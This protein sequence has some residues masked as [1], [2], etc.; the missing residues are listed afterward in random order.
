MQRQREGIAIAKQNGV[1]K[2]RKP[3]EHPRFSEIVSLWKCGTI[4]ISYWEL[5]SNEFQQI[6]VSFFGFDTKM[7]PIG[8]TL[9]YTHCA[10][11]LAYRPLVG[12][13]T[14]V[15]NIIIL[16]F[17]VSFLAYISKIKN[18]TL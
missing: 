4:L 15:C 10:L 13:H 11:S 1:F 12:L 7:T 6:W 8:S 14:Y 17:G 5:N 3:I 18:D 9:V 16:Q 2:G